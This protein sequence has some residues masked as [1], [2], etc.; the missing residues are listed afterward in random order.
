MSFHLFLCLFVLLFL[1]YRW[2]NVI[3]GCNITQNLISCV[4][5]SGT[6]V[7]FLFKR[8]EKLA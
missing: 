2:R 3:Y 4:C 7:S 1:C 5:A 6:S 8:Y